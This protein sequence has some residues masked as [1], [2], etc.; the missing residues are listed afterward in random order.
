MN[1]ENPYQQ[2]F[3]DSELEGFELNPL[4]VIVILIGLGLL[5][6]GLFRLFISSDSSVT[7]LQSTSPKLSATEIASMLAT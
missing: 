5:A 4:Q 7:H 6:I 1:N 2:Q 3:T